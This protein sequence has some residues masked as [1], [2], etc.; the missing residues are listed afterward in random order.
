M[1]TTEKKQIAARLS[2]YCG[3]KG[4]QSKAANSMNNVSVGTINKMLSG[5][6]E[7]ISDEMWRT[8][9][10]QIGHD[11]RGWTVVETRGYRRMY[12]LLRDAQENAL[13]LA[14]TGDA[15]CGKSEAV[16]SY[17]AGN[18][19][20]YNLSCSE[21]WNRRHFTSELLRSMGVNPSGSTVADMM[22]DIIR[23]LKRMENPLLVLDEADKLSDQSLY[24][25]ISLYN[26]LEDRVGIVLCAT[27]YLEKRIRQGVRT[28]R[29]GYREIYSRIGCRFI[30]L[31]AVNGEDIAAVC[32]GNGVGDAETINGIIEES[33]GD[34]RRVKRRVHALRQSSTPR[35]TA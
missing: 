34:L 18:A 10:S 23:A 29:K 19:N 1:K 24:F 13:V 7:M 17:A 4:S 11:P 28:N 27:D 16:R 35:R 20:V 14:V 22:D 9:A 6:W 15:G 21:Y 31:Q 30:P 8:V 26:Q 25:F 3:Q 33:E 5:D 32:M 2:G 12:G